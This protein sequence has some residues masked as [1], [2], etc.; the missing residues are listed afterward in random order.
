MTQVRLIKDK[1]H[2]NPELKVGT[3]GEYRN[4]T[5][6]DVYHKIYFPC[7]ARTIELFDNAFEYVLSQEE[8]DE[9]ERK[10]KT[11][12]DAI[13]KI[14]PRGGFKVLSFKYNYPRLGHEFIYDRKEGLK[15]IDFFKENNIPYETIVIKNS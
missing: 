12:F 15:I 11:A 4:S 13:Y 10:Y 6:L 3:I 9:Q 5:A 2:I 8:K 1:S 7:I 14:G